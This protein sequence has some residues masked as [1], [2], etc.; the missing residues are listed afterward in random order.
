MA[1]FLR[2]T[3]SPAMLRGKRYSLVSDFESRCARRFRFCACHTKNCTRTR[4]QRLPG[5]ISF[6]PF[7]SRERG[8]E[9]C[10]TFFVHLSKYTFENI[11]QAIVLL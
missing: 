4:I 2:M 3:T 5:S 8:M 10:T 7:P 6:V 1:W 9:Y 11:A